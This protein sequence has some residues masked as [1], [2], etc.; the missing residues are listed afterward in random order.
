[1]GDSPPHTAPSPPP[2]PASTG[3]KAPVRIRFWMVTEEA[4]SHDGTLCCSV[5]EAREAWENP[6]PIKRPKWGLQIYDTRSNSGKSMKQLKKLALKIYEDTWD[7]RSAMGRETLDRIDL[8]GLAM[9]EGTSPAKRAERCRGHNVKEIAARNATGK[10][11]FYI[12]RMDCGFPESGQR[13]ILIIDR[14][15][16]K[17]DEPDEGGFLH[18]QWDPEVR[19][20]KTESDVDSTESS[21]T[22]RREDE[23]SFYRYEYTNQVPGVMQGM[24]DGVEWFDINY[25]DSGLLDEELRQAVKKA[26]EK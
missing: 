6:E 12:P 5:W 18:V 26:S 13:S 11:D 16:D 19:E 20:D 9:S 8:Y 14:L 15:D 4:P 22:E 21:L 2:R 1:M 25:V 24:R 23:I 17:W 3:G 7:E 10:G